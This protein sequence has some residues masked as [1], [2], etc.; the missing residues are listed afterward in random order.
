MV[1]A[2]SDVQNQ[3]RFQPRPELVQFSRHLTVNVNRELHDRALVGQQ[4]TL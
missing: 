4:Q 2:K 3:R 1:F